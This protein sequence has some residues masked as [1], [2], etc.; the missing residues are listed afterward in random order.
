MNG[1]EQINQI[2]KKKILYEKEAKVSNI[3][4]SGCLIIFGVE[5]AK[6]QS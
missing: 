1:N 3:I 5:E 2:K 6:E 4:F